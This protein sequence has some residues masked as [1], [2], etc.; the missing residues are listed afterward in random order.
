MMKVNLKSDTPICGKYGEKYELER[1]TFYDKP[2][3]SGTL[4]P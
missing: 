1:A 3:K 2:F 4:G